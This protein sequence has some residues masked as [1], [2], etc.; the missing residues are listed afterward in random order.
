M[1]YNYIYKTINNI[2][3][4]YYL[5][6]HS[7]KNIDDSYLGSGTL[8]KKA[9]NKYGKE[10]FS[11]E[12]LTYCD[13]E[14]DCY[15]LEELVVTQI[16]L[17]DPMCYNIRIGGTGFAIGH[18][19]SK[20]TRLK[21]SKSSVGKHMSNDAKVKMS[22]AKIGLNHPQCRKVVKLDKMSLKILKIYNYIRQ[23]EVDGF[24]QGHISAC[25]SG[26]R[27]TH[28]GFKWRYINE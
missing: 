21:L 14:Q 23:T 22:N 27:Q 2:N 10:N 18:K 6:K 26:K 25:C 19:P 15:E 7:T 4:K 12:I 9:I 1:I 8:L 13:T 20:E 17:D 5:G 16:E 24:N 11:T 3:N 28:K